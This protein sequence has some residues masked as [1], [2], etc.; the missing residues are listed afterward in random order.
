MTSTET[1][2]PENAR[3]LIGHALTA[4]TIGLPEKQRPV[5]MSL[6]IPSLLSRANSEI[7]NSQGDEEAQIRITVYHETSIRMLELAGADQG[8]FKSIVGGMSEDQKRFLEEIIKS[9]R[10]RVQQKAGSDESKEP[11]IAL[12]MNFGK[13]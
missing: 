11:T 10:Q 3:G 5:A 12:T 8:A 13:A 7:E 4:F 9:G 1:E 6:V 2:D